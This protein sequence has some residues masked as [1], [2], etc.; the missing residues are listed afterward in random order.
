M[1]LIK[2]EGK[3]TQSEEGEERG[4]P[5]VSALTTATTK[6]QRQTTSAKQRQKQEKRILSLEAVEQGGVESP[7]AINHCNQKVLR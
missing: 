1:V 7:G 6:P 4:N 2:V 5:A 3:S